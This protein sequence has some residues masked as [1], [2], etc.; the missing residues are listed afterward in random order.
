MD[1]EYQ[2]PEEQNEEL[3][4][5]NTPEIPKLPTSQVPDKSEIWDANHAHITRAILDH[6]LDCRTMPSTSTIADVTGLSRETVR[7]HMKAFAEEPGDHN[8]LH[9]YNMMSEVIMAQ[10]ARAAISGDLKAAKLY[11]NTTQ[12]LNR[13]NKQ[14]T[15]GRPNNYIQIN[16]TVINQQVIQQLKPEQLN[17]I[18]QII[19]A[20]L[21]KKALGPE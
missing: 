10:V 5:E 17:Q 8:P 2:L 12:S 18:E 16:K 14:T 19:A 11:I 3:N 15:G 6:I 4:R 1:N 20:E 13:P 9:T 7:K 21:D